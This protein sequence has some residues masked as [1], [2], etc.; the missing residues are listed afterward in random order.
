MKETLLIAGI[1]VYVYRYRER[2]SP[3]YPPSGD[4]ETLKLLYLM[5]G[6]ERSAQES[7]E[8]AKVLLKKF[9]SIPDA[10]S[11]LAVI[12]FDHR[13][14][15]KRIVD[16]RRNLD[17]TDGN[18]THAADMLSMIEGAVVDLKTIHDYF[19]S[20]AFAYKYFKKV[21]HIVSGVSMGG[22]SAI[23]TA[24]RYPGLFDGAAPIVG[25]F[26]LTSL[27]LNRLKKWDK[28]TLYHQPYSAFNS[29]VEIGVR[30]PKALFDLSSREDTQV[31]YSYDIKKLKTFALFGK[32]DPAVPVKNSIPFLTRHD[33]R[34]RLQTDFD[35]H[36]QFQAIS[37][38]AKHEVT[39]EMV[40]DLAHWLVKF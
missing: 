13:N 19:P 39:N 12:T 21:V 10:A 3:F 40:N 2:S 34:M 28:T 26:D 18:I 1:E 5:H 11:S 33:Q 6:R 20:Y 14:H 31:E 17:W 9:Y 23:R 8:L 32:D 16:S 4:D 24:V 25:S 22:H 35:P 29:D 37:Y 7:E 27:L 15:G 30:Y 36:A 38:D